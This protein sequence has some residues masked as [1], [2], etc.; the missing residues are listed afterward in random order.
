MDVLASVDE[1]GTELLW[2][3]SLDGNSAQLLHNLRELCSVPAPTT[4]LAWHGSQ[5]G[6]LATVNGEGV[7]VLD[8]QSM[9]YVL[10]AV[11][12]ELHESRW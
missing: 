7:R 10:T 12:S 4:R 5:L 2:Q 1:D 8:L 11:R 9:V 3:V 6:L